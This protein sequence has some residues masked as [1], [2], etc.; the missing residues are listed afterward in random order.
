MALSLQHLRGKVFS[1]AAEGLSI[2]MASNTHLR[3]AEVSQLDVAGAI[4][5]HILWL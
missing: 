3:Q 2:T 4:D 1:G 5:E